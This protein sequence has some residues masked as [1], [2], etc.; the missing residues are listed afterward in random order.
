LVLNVINIYAA[1]VGHNENTEREF[2]EGLEDLVRSLSSG[3]KLFIGGDLNG[4]VGTFNTSCEGVHGGVAGRSG[5]T[6]S[7]VAGSGVTDR[8]GV[9]GLLDIS[10]VTGR[11]GLDVTGWSGVGVTGLGVNSRST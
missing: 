1:E 10:C 3:E 5:V 2:G 6:G 7:G 9:T 11:S 4:H 8:S